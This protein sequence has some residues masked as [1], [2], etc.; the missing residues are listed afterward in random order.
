MLCSDSRNDVPPVPQRN[1]SIAAE[2]GAVRPSTSEISYPILPFIVQEGIKYGTLR[3]EN[4]TFF[5]R[6][7]KEASEKLRKNNPNIAD[8][9]DVNRPT[10][11]VERFSE[12]YDNE[13]T[14][15]YI[16]ITET[17]RKEDRKAVDQ[18]YQIALVGQRD[19]F[20]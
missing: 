10:K 12:L 19:F 5:F 16:D 14:E 20:A 15:A 6:S 4:S 18:L 8:L 1:V 7:S 17:Q 2:R 13:W 11:T 9:S 3:E